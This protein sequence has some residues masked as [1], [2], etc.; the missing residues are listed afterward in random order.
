MF[1]QLAEEVLKPLTEFMFALPLSSVENLK[2]LSQAQEL[3]L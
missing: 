2:R 1:G 3:G